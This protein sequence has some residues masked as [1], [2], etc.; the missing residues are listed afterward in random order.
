MKSKFLMFL[1][2]TLVLC[3]IVFGIYWKYV[4]IADYPVFIESFDHG[5]LTVDSMDTT[6]TDNKYKVFWDKDEI[7][8]VNI[9]PER[10]ADSYYNLSKL[11][12]NGIDV[13]DQVSM[14]QYRTP[15]TEKLTILAYFKK[16]KA[17]E[18]TEQEEA[19]SKATAPVITKT[20]DNP[21]VGA[22]AAYDVEDPTVFYDE[23]SGL[24][25]CFGSDN[26]VIKSKDLVNWTGRTTYFNTPENAN[27]NAIMD[28]SQFESV[29]NWAAAHGYSDVYATSDNNSDRTPLAPEVVKIGSVYYLYFSLSKQAGAN[30]SAIFVVKTNNLETSLSTKKWV[31]GGMVICSCG[32]HNG[33][34]K[35]TDADGNR[36]ETAVTAQYDAANAVHPSV[37]YDGTNMYMVYGGYYGSTDIN[38]GIYLL[39]LDASTGLLK[40]GS[41]INAAGDRIGTIHADG[42]A[43]SGTLLAKPGRAPALSANST[44]LIGAPDIIY[45]S[46]TGYYYLF[47]TYGV[48][49]TNYNIRV[50]RSTNVTGPY[51]D[52]KGNSMIDLTGNQYDKGYML[53]GGYCFTSSSDGCVSYTDTGRAS[54]GSPNLIKAAN[55]TWL[56]A[57]QSQLYY[58]VGS[59]VV[60][61]SLIAE[62]EEI[63]VNSE[64]C[65]E[66]REL[67]WD[68]TGWPLAMPEVFSGKTASKEV[69]E[70]ELLGNWDVLVFDSAADRKDYRAVARSSSHRLS[71]FSNAIITAK[72]IAGNK[73]LTTTGLPVKE[74]DCYKMTVDGVEY[75]IYLRYMWDWELE[76]GS[77]VFTGIGADGSVM[78][79]KKNFSPTTGMYTDAFYYLYDKCDDATKAEIDAKVK[80]IS[81]NPSQTYIDTIS[82]AI[83]KRLIAQAAA[84]NNG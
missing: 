55:G 3:G 33:T 42:T 83:I 74:G 35:T 8:T 26:V 44:S 46:A 7:I 62:E 23:D 67:T 16:G 51:T 17:P 6:G 12:V 63:L 68:N 21:Y 32:R 29:K 14:L 2:I 45:N 78:W 65:L 37:L 64:P 75:K 52:F 57:S 61:G 82:Q 69:D 48:D 50:S 25:Y 76:E 5:V 22:Y 60:T 70:N 56:M 11:V 13:T 81:A 80:K 58:K 18:G 59:N 72:D 66:I 36:V 41:T 19:E 15:V 9:N 4:R 24:Y 79:G 71:V 49:D 84:E 34:E 77:L 27:T 28:F 54:V 20:Y 43:T 39:E 30:E 40:A 38:G 53:L 1:T 47:T 10:T 31:D 73:E